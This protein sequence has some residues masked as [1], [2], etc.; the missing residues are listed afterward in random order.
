ML[1][2]ADLQTL[3]KMTE[4]INQIDLNK[5]HAFLRSRIKNYD[6]LIEKTLAQ[7]KTQYLIGHYQKELKN[8]HA[9]QKYTGADYLVQI[10]A[11]ERLLKA[12]KFA[13]WD[14][15]NSIVPQTRTQMRVSILS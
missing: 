11:V 7:I 10:L 6:E 9:D 14:E 5:V 8:L 2:P 1:L 3:E 12:I 13:N 4:N 15:V